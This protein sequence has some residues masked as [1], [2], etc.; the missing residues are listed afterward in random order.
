MPVFLRF[1]APVLEEL[2]ARGGA[3]AASEI[4]EA[5]IAR[6]QL[7]TEEAAEST[8][9]ESLLTRIPVPAFYMDATDDDRWLVVDGLQRLT[10]LRRF[11]VDQEFA[12]SELEF[13]TDF[14]FASVTTSRITE[15][16]STRRSS[17]AG[18]SP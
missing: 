16:P 5:V 13:L 2:K 14:S 17:S 10:V 18:R 12:L 1:L 6:L 11:V 15:S 8:L 3:A 9:I 7:S 4:T